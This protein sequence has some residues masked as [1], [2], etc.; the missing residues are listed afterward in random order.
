[1]ASSLLPSS[2][3]IVSPSFK[4]HNNRHQPFQ[5][6]AQSCRD[7]GGRSSNG[8]DANLRVLKERIDVVK[9][10]EKL[11]RCCRYEYGWNYAKGFNYNK[12][13][14]NG[15]I[16]ELFEL[17]A[18]LNN[19]GQ[20]NEKQ[21]LRHFK[22][23]RG[24]G[25]DF[26]F[27]LLDS[28]IEAGKVYLISEGSLK[29]AQKEYNDHNNDH[30]ILLASTKIV[31]QCSEDD[32]M[33]PRQHFHFRTISDVEGMKNNDVVDITG[34]FPVL[35]VKSSTASDF[36]GKEVGT[37]PSTQLFINPDFPKA[38]LSERGR[39][40]LS[41]SIAREKSSR[42]KTDNRKTIS[43]IKDERLGSSEKPDWITVVAV[44]AYIELD[45]F[46]YP[47]CPF[48]DGCLQCNKKVTENV[49]G[50]WWCDKCDYRCVIQ[51]Q[52]QDHTSTTWV[53]A[54][55]ESGESLG[56]SAKDLY[57]LKYEDQNVEKFKEIIHQILFNKNTF[58]L[59]VKEEN[60]NSKSTVVTVESKG[61][62]Y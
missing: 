60:F 59:K 48:M 22:N 45:N 34:V 61:K 21:K 33:I 18:E 4:H 43:Q 14:R 56:V 20:S 44:I 9:M 46:Y 28:I 39:N 32:D 3:T 41:V 6:R 36:S 26:S 53:I 30:Q 19:K 49:D 57:C 10:K 42:N 27:K 35:A 38:R 12:V 2:V 40:T 23:V 47:A 1:M 54:F 37:I 17:L 31:Q 29:L 11:E 13:K 5:V 7:G 24:E 58:K 55:E 50:K 25:K 15:E 51:L 8:V 16:S 62:N 52:I